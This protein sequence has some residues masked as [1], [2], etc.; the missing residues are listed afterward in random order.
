MRDWTKPLRKAYYDALAGN[1]SIEAAIVPVW[2]DKVPE[3]QPATCYI[4]IGETQGSDDSTFSTWDSDAFINVEVIAHFQSETGDYVDDMTDQVKSLL[5]PTRTTIG[6]TEP[7]GF[8]IKK[9][10]VDGE[11]D[12]PV[13]Q[14]ATGYL[15]RKIIRYRQKIVDNN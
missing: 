7:S 10:V 9:M 11:N 8:H 12:I 15:K 6:I 5:L 4:V 13:L 1:V 2:Q 14:T 3:D